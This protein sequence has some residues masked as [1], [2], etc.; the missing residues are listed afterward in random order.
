MADR[1]LV[2]FIKEGLRRGYS[3]EYLQRQLVKKGWNL[4]EVDEAIDTVQTPPPPTPSPEPEQREQPLPP[5]IPPGGR[6][7]PPRPSGPPRPSRP[8]RPVGVTVIACLSFLGGIL[9]LITGILILGF[10]G[11]VSVDYL[12]P[13]NETSIGVPFV[14]SLEE[15]NLMTMLG[16]AFIVMGVIELAGSFLLLGMKRSGWAI[17]TAVGLIQIIGYS[18]AGVISFSIGLEIILILVFW[19]VII[20]YLFTKRKLFL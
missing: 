5:Q 7:P 15:V 10:V 2:N 16:L 20:G 4:D 3:A 18:A 17:I 6:R 12:S 1:R 8:S 14:S 13:L 11:L 19:I 9:V